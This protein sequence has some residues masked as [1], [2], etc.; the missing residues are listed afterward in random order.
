MAVG[1]TKR[2][3]RRTG[4]STNRFIRQEHLGQVL[5]PILA[6][7]KPASSASVETIYWD[8][9]LPGFGV[10]AY[11][12]GRRVYFVQYRERGRTR[13]RAIAAVDEIEARTARRRARKILSEVA[14]GLGVEDPFKVVTDTSAFRFADMA[15]LYLASEERR[16][17]EATRKI[18]RRVI[19]KQFLPE[20]GATAV[21]DITR[22]TVLNWFDG[23]SD[24]PG[25]ANRAIPVLSGMMKFAETLK[26]RP[27]NSNPCR[28]ITRYK[29]N[30]RIRFLSIDELARLGEALSPSY[31]PG[32]RSGVG[33][34]SLTI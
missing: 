26:L 22:E 6:D 9:E 27:R 11:A 4:K 15:P 25:L 7:A 5:Q 29:A 18:T 17:K 20:F 16:W 32:A 28:N 13:R 31:S 1:E 12:T 19:D 23:M 8:N 14:I 24:R 30:N 34:R 10:R 21:C 3:G 2:V 33:E